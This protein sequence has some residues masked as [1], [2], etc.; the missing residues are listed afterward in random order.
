MDIGIGLDFTL[1]LGYDEQATV[2]AE[3]ARA[4]YTSIWTPENIGE[5]SFQLCLLRWMATREAVPGGIGTGIGVSPVGMRTPMGFAMSAGTMSKATGGKFTLGIGT[6]QAYNA[7]YRRTW[8]M[9]GKS[10]LGLMRDYLTI[11]RSL[12]NGETVDYE[13]PSAAL[14]GARLAINPPPKTPVYLAALGPEM[15][16]LAGEA[17]DGVSLNWCNAD[18]VDWSRQLVREG[19]E[20]AGRDPASVKVAEYIRVCVDDDVDVA[21]RA[22]ARNM[23]G[24]ALGP[25]DVK[26]QSYRAHFERMGWGDDLRRIDDL[27][28]KQAPV[29][30]VVDAFP[31]QMLLSVG[32][33]GRAAGAREHFA[34]L[35][36]G[37][38]TAIVRVIGARPGIDA[39]RA[40]LWA[41]A[42]A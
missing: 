17:A 40:V 26:P 13:G 18:A 41:C 9:Q 33:F 1:G 27:R 15:C 31:P 16:K 35:A 22:F 12:V 5:D 20:K 7:K 6:G 11:V 8:N 2:S 19:A 14:H 21:R 32:Y 10:T 36:D 42:P 34:K 28:R 37:L 4:G 30:E 25:L 38:D 29:D 23:M 39:T 3:A 24:Y